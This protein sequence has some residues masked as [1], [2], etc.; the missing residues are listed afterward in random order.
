[1][2]GEFLEARWKIWS[3]CLN[4]GSSGTITDYRLHLLAQISE[5]EKMFKHNTT[6]ANF[7]KCILHKS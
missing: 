4:V 1:M 6:A 3:F 5:T 7:N 2:D